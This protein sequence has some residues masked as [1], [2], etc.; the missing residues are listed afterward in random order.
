MY[1]GQIIDNTFC[2]EAIY[3]KNRYFQLFVRIVKNKRLIQ[4][5]NWNVLEDDVIF[6]DPDYLLDNNKPLP[7]ACYVQYWSEY[8]TVNGKIT[9]S[10]PKYSNCKNVGRKNQRNEVI[11]ALNLCLSMYKKKK[12]S[13]TKEVNGDGGIIPLM[14][15]TENSKNNRSYPMIGQFKLDG[16]RCASFLNDTGDVV[17]Y[18]KGLKYWPDSPALRPI[19]NAIQLLLAGNNDL[20]LDGELYCHG[21]SLQQVSCV[22]SSSFGGYIEY[23]IFDCF[24]SIN[25]DMGFIDRWNMLKQMKEYDCIKLVHTVTLN[26]SKEEDELFKKAISSGY[27]GIVLRGPHSLY[28]HTR[29]KDVIRRK[30]I[31]DSEFEVIGYTDG[32][33]K[34]S[35]AILWICTTITGKKFKATPKGMTTHERRTL[36]TYCEQFFDSKYKNRLMKVEYRALSDEGIP[37]RAKAIGFRDYI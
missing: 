12:T 13:I 27:E 29:S 18:T 8:G 26:D 35:K 15:V 2:F 22:R 5:T 14:L 37:L 20:Y 11:Q 21:Y 25:K 24:S 17:M 30:K 19:R 32:K 34:D 6:F 33:G 28:K 36:Y 1:P 16:N 4:N 23:H 10:A 3:E 7:S 9:R 31:H